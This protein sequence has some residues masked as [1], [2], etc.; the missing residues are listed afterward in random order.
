MKAA[1]APRV[2]RL[3]VTA[4]LD[5]SAD[6]FEITVFQYSQIWPLCPYRFVFFLGCISSMLRNGGTCQ[7]AEVLRFK[8][9]FQQVE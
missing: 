9:T 8:D 6:R 1:H 3:Y 2:W 7:L 4:L 5:V